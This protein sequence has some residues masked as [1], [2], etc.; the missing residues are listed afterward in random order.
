MRAA[1]TTMLS[2]IMIV[3]LMPVS[4]LGSASGNCTLRRVWRGVAPNISAASTVAA[5]TVRI[6]R[7]VSRTT[8]GSAYTTEAMMAG[9]RATPNSSTTGIR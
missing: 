8:G 1:I 4:T 3:W 7:S 5:G 2:A 6:P 9:T